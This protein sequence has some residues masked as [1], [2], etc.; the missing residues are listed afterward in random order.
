MGNEEYVLPESINISGAAADTLLASGDGDAALLY[1]YILRN[2]GR[3]NIAS[4]DKML[5]MNGRA[6]AAARSLQNMGLIKG[7]A[8]ETEE[9]KEPPKLVKPGDNLPEYTGEDAGRAVNSDSHF[10]ALVTEVQAVLGTILTSSGLKELLGFYD[11]LGLPS[12]VILLLVAHCVEEHEKKFGQ[13]KRPTMRAIRSEAYRWA[14]K[15]VFSLEAANEMIKSSE[16]A[17]KRKSEIRRILGLQDR[18][19]SPTEERCISEWAEAGYGD[20]L[21]NAAYDKTVLNTGRLVWK[22]MDSILKSWEQKG[23]KTLDE[24]RV[25]DRKPEE[26]VAAERQ[27]TSEGQD[28]MA[29]LKE[30]LKKLKQSGE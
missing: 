12:D 17:K 15:G 5:G 19:P 26:E 16:A 13:G 20:E 21:I 23:L 25:G 6:A 9:R 27:P 24:V 30:Y 18:S 4:A 29:R 28:E 22:Y 8:K 14:D 7:G 2:G 10:A 3:L 11:Y 1:I